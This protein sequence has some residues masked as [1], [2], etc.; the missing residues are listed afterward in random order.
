MFQVSGPPL[1]EGAPSQTDKCK[2]RLKCP[3]HPDQERRWPFVRSPHHFQSHCLSTTQWGL[4]NPPQSGFL[5]AVW[6]GESVHVGDS[7][8]SSLTKRLITVT[9]ARGLSTC[10][11]HGTFLTGNKSGL[12]LSYCHSQFRW[13][14]AWPG[15]FPNTHKALDAGWSVSQTLDPTVHSVCQTR[16]PAPRPQLPTLC[17]DV[18]AGRLRSAVTKCQCGGLSFGGG[19]R[20]QHLGS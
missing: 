10:R 4:K 20:E 1:R 17:G 13:S 7:S 8:R 11:T 19:L 9:A 6:S 12:L 16:C 2:R 15:G 18:T 14:Q 3:D 5:R